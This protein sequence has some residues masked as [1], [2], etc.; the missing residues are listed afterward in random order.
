M[1]SPTPT[2][3]N[4]DRL[5]HRGIGVSIRRCVIRVHGSVDMYA[6]T[7]SIPFIAMSDFTASALVRV[8]A[9]LIRAC[10]LRSRAY[11]SA[12]DLSRS[13]HTRAF[14][15]REQFIRDPEMLIYMAGMTIEIT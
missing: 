12:L 9:L 13:A 8:C 6:M 4:V 2:V 3:D 15:V 10:R 1:E 14:W 11:T 7:I 5:R